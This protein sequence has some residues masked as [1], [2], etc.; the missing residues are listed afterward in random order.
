[1]AA[2]PYTPMPGREWLTLD[3]PPSAKN[4]FLIANGIDNH[5]YHVHMGSDDDSMASV[6]KLSPKHGSSD[7]KFYHSCLIH[8]LALFQY[9]E[10]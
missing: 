7:N 8:D 5:I 6:K 2:H 4:Q 9:R 1:M 10:A 3:S